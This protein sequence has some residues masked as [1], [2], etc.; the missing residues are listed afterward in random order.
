ML[1][2]L[3]GPGFAT[4][5]D[6]PLADPCFCWPYSGSAP[7]YGV[8]SAR[9]CGQ[10]AAVN[11]D[12]RQRRLTGNRHGEQPESS[13]VRASSRRS[14]REPPP[15]W[16][17]VAARRKD[18]R[19]LGPT[20]SSL[21]SGKCC[22]RLRGWVPSPHGVGGDVRSAYPAVDAEE[23]YAVCLPFEDAL[24]V[25][26]QRECLRG[27]GVGVAQRR[28]IR[29]GSPAWVSIGRAWPLPRS[30]SVR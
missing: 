6:H 11:P 9:P 25:A 14:G 1:I 22:E 8:T 10:S 15:S 29:S 17:P 19:S 2:I 16:M 3:P 30:V 24:A 12:G 7:R 27:E 20:A 28:G 23:C 4:P 21:A 5:P 18:V 26:G 13:R